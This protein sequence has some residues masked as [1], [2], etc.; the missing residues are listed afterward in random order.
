MPPAFIRLLSPDVLTQL[1]S[2]R[3]LKVQ[4]GNTS[5]AATYFEGGTWSRPAVIV[6]N[7]PNG[8]WHGEIP[9]PTVKVWMGE[10][11][12]ILNLYAYRIDSKTW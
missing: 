2:G 3:I 11:R 9:R 12:H 10:E 7:P 1:S 8:G 6:R 5:P 4:Q